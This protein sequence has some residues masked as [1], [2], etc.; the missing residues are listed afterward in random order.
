MALIKKDASTATAPEIRAR[1]T[2][3]RVRDYEG[4]IAQLDDT[5]P[6]ARRWAARDLVEYP[7]ATEALLQ[8]LHTEADVSVRDGILTTLTRLGHE[9][10]VTGLVAC[11]R[12][13]DVQLR[14]AAIE[15]MKALPDDVA[16]IMSALLLDADPDVRILALNVL[17]SLR[18]PQ[19]EEWLIAVIDRDL[20]VNVCGTAVDL[21]GE[22]GS[23]A[24]QPALLRLKLR[25]PE[26]P[27]IQFAADLAL[28][29]I[30]AA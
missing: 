8:R 30:A 27:Y 24:A 26:E 18:H 5:E 1:D 17:E 19:V 7:A 12:S 21:L 22:V 9:A 23:V 15:A 13:E 29:R 11:L 3:V 28:Q 14:N 10:A 20:A 6:E 4:L 25:F 16:P 2:R